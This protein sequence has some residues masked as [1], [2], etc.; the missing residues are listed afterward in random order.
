MW[1][2]GE[3]RYLLQW[4]AA[5]QWAVSEATELRAGQI[6]LMSH[7]IPSVYPG[8]K[9]FRL[10]WL[11]ASLRLCR[12]SLRAGGLWRAGSCPMLLWVLV[13]GEASLSGSYRPSSCCS[14][15]VS[16]LCLHRETVISSVSSSYKDTSIIGIRPHPYDLIDPLL[17]PHRLYLEMQSHWGLRLQCVNWGRERTQCHL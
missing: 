17:P 9:L 8:D 14:H 3:T 12:H 4:E 5:C 6:L 2:G 10:R 1:A 7:H 13:S 11:S 15:M 16:S